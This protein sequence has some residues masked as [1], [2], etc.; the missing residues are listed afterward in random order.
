MDR[1]YIKW[2][3]GKNYKKKQWKR[4][5]NQ[6]RDSFKGD[7]GKIELMTIPTERNLRFV[8]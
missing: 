4:G 1:S 7:K 5:K 3:P 2:K 6:I 8:F